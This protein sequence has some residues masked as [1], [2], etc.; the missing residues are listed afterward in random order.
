MNT[1]TFEEFEQSMLDFGA[2]QYDG[3]PDDDDPLAHAFI[4]GA[5]DQVTLMAI[6]PDMFAPNNLKALILGVCAE[7]QKYKAVRLAWLL[8]AYKINTE[9]DDRPLPANFADDDRAIEV[10]R[11]VTID[12]ERVSEQEALVLRGP[13]RLG[14]WEEKK[15]SSSPY[16]DL[17]QKALAL[18]AVQT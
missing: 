2:T 18:V 4:V 16:V 10:F 17:P 14:P 3:V 11:C 6:T 9:G 8:P 15:A 7:I 1:K 5:D 12:I 13:S